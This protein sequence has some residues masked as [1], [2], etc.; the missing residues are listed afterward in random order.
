M[1]PRKS[2]FCASPEVTLLDTYQL[3][4]FLLIT[5]LITLMIC[6]FYYSCFSNLPVTLKCLAWMKAWVFLFSFTWEKKR[7]RENKGST[8]KVL[9][10]APLQWTGAENTFFHSKESALCAYICSL[11][12]AFQLDPV[13]ALLQTCT[14]GSSSS[15]FLLHLPTLLHIAAKTPAPKRVVGRLEMRQKLQQ[16]DA[17]LV[18]L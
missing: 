17:V 4:I 1:V 6:F 7:A 11:G 5:T 2:R 13:L 3:T 15:A 16:K 8:A 14:N 12:G 18:P 10:K 9:I